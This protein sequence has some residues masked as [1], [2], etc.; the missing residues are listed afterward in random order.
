MPDTVRRRVSLEVPWRTLL[1]ILAA[2]ALVWCVLRL[3]QIILLIIVAVLLAV[4]LHPI[5]CWLERRSLPRWA[6]ATIVSLGILTLVGGFFWLTW[7]SLVDQA[8]Y[9]SENFTD[10]RAQVTEYV[11]PW[12]LSAVGTDPSQ[13]SSGG[14]NIALGVV[15]SVS[16][17][18]TLIVLGFILTIYLL[19]ESR[20]TYD[21]VLAFVPRQHRA[22]AE[23]TAEECRHVIFGYMAGNVIT[24]IIATVVTLIALLVLKVPAALLLALMAGLSD[25]VPV[26]GFIASAVP[27]IILAMTVSANTALIV[28][29]VY[30]AYN[31]V[32]NY[33]I[34]P[35]AYGNRLKLS[36]VAVVL[37]FVVGAQLGGVIGA[38]IALP[39]AAIYPSIERIWLREKLPEDTVREHRALETRKAG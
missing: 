24:S 9:L 5:V 20:R 6:A 27:A 2:A 7:A 17:A 22:K 34:A 38:L 36:N 32:E 19:V 12:L 26:I 39:L 28:V 21:W 29:A 37:A 11:P 30:I 4:T 13:G 35:W 10:V 23:K 18:I 31:A 1:K 25:F 16:S 3:T 15:R 8:K 33:L 14:G